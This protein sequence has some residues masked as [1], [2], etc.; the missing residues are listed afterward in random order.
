[1][2]II[3]I[4][5]KDILR[6]KLVD[7]GWYRVKIE[8]IGEKTSKSGDSQNFPVEATILFNSETKSEEFKGVP[9]NWNFN[10]KA[11]G[12]AVGFLNALDVAVPPDGGRFELSAAIG[13]V[14]DVT[15]V[16]GEY[17]GRP[18]NRVEHKYRKPVD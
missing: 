13:K 18:V 7:P 17:E 2:P 16:R 8:D 3:S 1:M 11:M 4:T 15:V 10:E 6:G 12:F 5:Q 9:L 14:I